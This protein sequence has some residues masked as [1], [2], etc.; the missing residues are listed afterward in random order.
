MKIDQFKIL[1]TNTSASV[2]KIKA[3]VVGVVVVGL[4]QMKIKINFLK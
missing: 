2:L 3:A 4:I 1:F